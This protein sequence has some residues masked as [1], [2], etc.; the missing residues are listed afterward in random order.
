MPQEQLTQF[1][2]S[3]LKEGNL[4]RHEASTLHKNSVA[5]FLGLQTETYGAPSKEVQGPLGL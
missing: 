2:V 3:K 1:L 4:R 5:S